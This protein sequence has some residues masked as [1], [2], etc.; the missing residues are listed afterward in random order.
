[1]SGAVQQV[2][3]GD[4]LATAMYFTLVS[5]AIAL[6]VLAGTTLAMKRTGTFTNTRFALAA[7]AI[8]LAAK[9]AVLHYSH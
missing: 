4:E 3:F 6:P 9:E 8:G 5:S 2:T 7:V 1:M